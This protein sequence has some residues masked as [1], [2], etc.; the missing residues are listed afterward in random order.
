[1]F[2]QVDALLAEHADLQEQLADPALHSEPA[3]AKKVNQRYAELSKIKAA[4]ENWVQ[5]G[6]DLSA[7]KELAREDESF[8]DEVPALETELAA[9]QEKVRRLLIPRDPDDARDV[10]L[11]IKGGEGGAESALF[12][13]DL[14]R[15]YSYYAESKGWKTEILESDE[16]D[17]GGYK[18]VQVAI[19]ANAT[20][21]SQGAWAH[22]KY[23]GGVHRV[24][25]VPV[26]ESQGRIHT[27]TTG[28]LVYPEVDEPEE[29]E[30]NQNDLKID[31][32]RSSGPGGQSVNTTDSAV[33]IT[34]LP[35]GI[36][37]AMQNEKSQLQNREAAM[38]VLRARLLAKQ[39]EEAEA[40]ASAHRKSQIRTMDR[41]ERI[42]TYNFPENRIA[43]HRTGFKAYNLD[44][45]MNGALGPVIDSCIHADEES[46]LAELGQES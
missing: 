38:R 43:D 8:A 24:Q 13:A 30:I 11:E 21:P 19:K 9:A 23:E 7:A 40:E 32:Y 41:S 29:V 15:M 27:S 6:E 42:R 5:L 39:Q 26:T 44:Q 35:S 31:V 28:V 2:E 22:L 34:H 46:R 14:L 10:I 20:D 45:V 16:S 12:A 25:R 18:N 17:L 33:R 37:V 3:R 1:M 4:H 36:V